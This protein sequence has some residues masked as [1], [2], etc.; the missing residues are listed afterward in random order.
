MRAAAVLLLTLLTTGALAQGSGPLS[1]SDDQVQ[2]MLS[3]ALD[4]IGRARCDNSQPCSA[5]T[6]AEKESP[7]ITI[8]EAR[9]IMHRG[10]LS[11]A[12]EHCG[13][14]WQARNFTPMMAYWR[15]DMKK[16][17]RQ[18]A[19]V[20]MLHGIMQG[21]AKPT[22]RAPCSPSERQNLEQVLPFK[23]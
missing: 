18:M 6:A 5:A 12:G 14:D 3:L 21:M 20:G 19:L 7:P 17:E 10:I 13:L 9:V 8:A 15:R 16:T 22:G 4:N 11:A 23:P 1:F 2:R